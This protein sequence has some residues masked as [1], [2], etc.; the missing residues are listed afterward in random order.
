MSRSARRSATFYLIAVL[1]PF[2]L[3]FLVE[4]SLRTFDYGKT[5]PLFVDVPGQPGMIQ[6]NDEVIKRFFAL[7]EM[8]PAVSPDTHYF[9]RIK[10]P[11]T[12][13]IVVQ[14]GSTAAGFPY[15]RWGS[16][17]GMLQQRFK[18][19][20]PERDIEVINTAMSSVNS[21]TLMDFTDE[22]IAIEPDIVLVYAG[23]NEYL[24]VLGVGSALAAKGGRG[25]TLLH[26]KL[27]SLKLYQLLEATYY[28]VFGNK[29]DPQDSRTLMAKVAREKD[30][31]IGS[32]L[33]QAGVEQ[34]EGN[35][36]ILLEAYRR[37]DIPVVIGNLVSNEKD[38]IPFSAIEAIDGKEQATW[39][40]LT[41]AQ[42]KARISE[43]SAQ[44][45]GEGAKQASMQFE[46]GTLLLIEGDAQKAL[47]HFQQARDLDTL[48][49][50]APGQ[51]NAVIR[52][53]SENEG[54]FLADVDT[55][56]RTD[57][58]DG[59]IGEKHMLEHLHPTARG[60]FLLADAYLAS[61]L[62]HKLLDAPWS[63]NIAEAWQEM[64][65]TKA[66]E[67]YARFKI[68]RLKADYPFSAQ[69]QMVVMPSNKTLEGKAL[70][71]RVGGKDWLS[72]NRE[73]S[74]MYQRQQAFDEA[75]KIAGLLADALPHN[76]DLSYIAGLQYKKA[77]NLRLSLYYLNRTLRARPES[78]TTRLSIAQTYFMLGDAAKSL[79]HL[80]KAK[81]I[82][83][84]HPHVDAFIARVTAA[85][86]Q[87]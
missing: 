60:Y 47:S 64:P 76:A 82:N 73:L 35:M 17:S 46:L 5:Y 66:D 43:L 81:A 53:L 37:A 14:G 42:R 20:F 68:D 45:E 11:E 8:A 79:V 24:G 86:N 54:V 9:P 65:V 33:Y 32:A 22:I 28:R 57:T 3:L 18:R 55:R 51:F 83:P 59:I 87:Q 63:D 16:L 6:P 30:I 25:A 21:Y 26:L 29:P 4:V 49:F 85:Q 61:I 1:L 75:A 78:L 58:Q 62:R 44:V 72:I 10:G 84:E 23:H 70:H 50:R 56:I 2:V 34:F 69:K 27:K 19:L 67:M 39:E 52:T 12:F 77:N 7:P 41:Q 15:G 36:T 71:D 74:P 40:Q 38:L 48:R 13:R 80:R 31:P